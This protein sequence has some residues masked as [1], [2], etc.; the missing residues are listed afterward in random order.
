LP[1]RLKSDRCRTAPINTLPAAPNP[2]SGPPCQWTPGAM[3]VLQ[4]LSMVTLLCF[5]FLNFMLVI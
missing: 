3:T 5:H 1:R 4:R 2:A